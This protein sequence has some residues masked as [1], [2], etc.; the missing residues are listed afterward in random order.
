MLRRHR[1]RRAEDEQ[2]IVE[3]GQEVPQVEDGQTVDVHQLASK[4]A[5][6]AKMLV[7]YVP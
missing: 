6:S 2:Q 1:N 7:V 3:V 4:G 5:E